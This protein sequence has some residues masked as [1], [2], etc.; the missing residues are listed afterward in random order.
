[1]GNEV[2]IE[3][4]MVPFL[5]WY[6][7]IFQ[8]VEVEGVEFHDMRLTVGMDMFFNFFGLIPMR[9]SQLSQTLTSH[10]GKIAGNE[11]KMMSDRL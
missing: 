3:A 11:N 9:C 8:T 7:V 1:L 2:T 5:S 6:A 4:P 10:K